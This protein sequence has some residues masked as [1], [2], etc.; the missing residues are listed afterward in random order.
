[1]TLNSPIEMH[2]MPMHTSTST[3]ATTTASTTTNTTAAS[4][5]PQGYLRPPDINNSG[6]NSRSSWNSRT[7]RTHSKTSLAIFLTSDE[8]GPSDDEHIAL[9]P[10]GI[11]RTNTDDSHGNSISRSS[12]S[13]GNDNDGLVSRSS[14]T[15]T[16]PLFRQKTSKQ[17]IKELC[18][19]VMPALLVSVAGSICAGYILG[20]IQNNR[21]FD[22][23]PAFFIMVPVLLNLKSNTELNMSTRMSTLANLGSFDNTRE[24]LRTIKSNLLLLLLQSTAVGASV[25]LISTLLSLLPFS[26]SNTTPFFRQASILMASGIGCAV[27]GSTMVGLLISFTIYVSHAYG[28]DPDNIGT[29]IASSFGD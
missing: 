2:S 15:F 29:P 27:I 18:I 8:E 3:E 28:V 4:S 24:S 16:D 1:M 5:D 13:N 25:G 17:I 14:S 12:R 7:S 6:R 10:T 20:T 23:I 19:E 26:G 22:R 9:T 11:S 21:A